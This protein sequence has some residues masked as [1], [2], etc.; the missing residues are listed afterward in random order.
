M[1]M[2]SGRLPGI[3]LA[4]CC[5]LAGCSRQDRVARALPDTTGGQMPAG[6]YPLPP[7]RVE[8]PWG[9]VDADTEVLDLSCLTREQ[10][11]AAAEKLPLLNKVTQVELGASELTP[12]DVLRLRKALPEAEFHY[13]FTLL[14][15]PVS[16][17]DKAVEIVNAA[18]PDGYEQELRQALELMK[19]CEILRLDNCGVENEVMAQIRED[20]RGRTKVV[21]RVFFAKN[22]SCMTDRK[23]IRYVY[24]MDDSNCSALKYCED[25]EYVDFGHNETLTDC[26]WAAG[27]PRLKAAI[28]SGSLVSDLSGFSACKDLE[29]LE[30]AYCSRV[31]DL[32]PLENC[33]KLKMVNTSFTGVSDFSPLNGAPLERLCSVSSKAPPQEQERFRQAHPNCLTLFRGKQP[34]GYCW[35]YEKDGYT[36]TGYYAL[37]K[38][39][40]HYPDTHDTTW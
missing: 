39:V 5:I 11:D 19:D 18:A 1:K 16:T 21:W 33:R 28:L 10:V 4:M 15:Q 27:M 24:N 36:P 25:A 3:L 8:L 9:S 30:L 13:C 31:T 29:F 7:G 22:G 23:V 32:S 34:Y 37:L 35:R 20:Y 40:F 2:K 14:G 12:G 17:T 6:Q 38:E 26:S